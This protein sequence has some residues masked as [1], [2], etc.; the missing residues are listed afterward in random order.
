MKTSRTLSAV[1]RIGSWRIAAI[2]ETVLSVW[3]VRGK[4][5]G[6]GGKRPLA[7]LFDGP[8]GL[9]GTDAGGSALDREEIERLLPGALSRFTASGTGNEPE[10]QEDRT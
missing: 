1:R 8:D 4:F 10:E 3:A 6:S 2:E 5:G 9:R 7:F